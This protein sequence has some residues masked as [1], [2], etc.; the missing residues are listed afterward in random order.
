MTAGPAPAPMAE[1][2]HERVAGLPIVSPHGHCDPRW[3]AED[4]AFP[5]PA[6]LLIKPDHYVFRMLYSQGVPLADLGIGP[7]GE[8]RDPRDVFQLFVQHWDAFLGTPSRQWLEFTLVRTLGI[9]TPLSPDTADIVYAQIAE[10]LASPAFQPRA[11]FDRFGIEVLATT[12]AATDRLQKI[13][14]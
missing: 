1:A 4:G 14:P 7:D 12:D 8:G 2:L 13:A 11:L 5:D 6:D 10:R 9:D 3:W